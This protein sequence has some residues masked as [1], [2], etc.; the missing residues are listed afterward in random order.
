VQNIRPL[1]KRGAVKKVPSRGGRKGAVEL[2]DD[3]R[4][5]LKFGLTLW[6]TAK[7]SVHQ[8]TSKPAENLREA[9]PTLA[10][11][12]QNIAEIG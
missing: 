4:E 5:L 12:H 3:G 1:E 2:T 9:S 6:R 7:A 10:H 11:Q 8:T